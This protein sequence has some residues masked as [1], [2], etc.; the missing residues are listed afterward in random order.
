MGTDGDPGQEGFAGL[1]GE[2]G[3]PPPNGGSGDKGDAGDYGLIGRPGVK[4]LDGEL[5][6]FSLLNSFFF[7]GVQLIC[8]FGLFR[9][10]NITTSPPLDL[11]T[12]QNGS[13]KNIF[14]YFM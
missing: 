11:P 8:I 6:K 9:F 2:K 1:T 7:K 5:G 3:L 12:E 13:V 14:Y 4:G 10:P